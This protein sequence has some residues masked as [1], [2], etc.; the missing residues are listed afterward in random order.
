MRDYA[1][2][3]GR[4][5]SILKKLLRARAEHLEETNIQRKRWNDWFDGYDEFLHPGRAV[6]VFTF[7]EFSQM[8]GVAR[9]YERYPK[10]NEELAMK[11]FNKWNDE[12]DPTLA[13]E[14][15]SEAS[16]SS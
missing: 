4:A 11:A 1:G 2:E 16:S 5:R 8:L 7:E 10:P 3:L 12:L 15:F 14:S 13:G 6:G 9:R